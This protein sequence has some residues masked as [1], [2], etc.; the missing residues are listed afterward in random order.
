MKVLARLLNRRATS[1]LK[2]AVPAIVIALSLVAIA[3]GDDGGDQQRQTSPTA[4]SNP[5]TAPNLSAVVVTTMHVVGPNRF[6][7]GIIDQDAGQPVL[8]GQIHFRFFEVEGSQAELR[9]ESD[10]E[11]I[12]FDTFFVN[13]DTG[14]QIITG[15]TGVYVATVEF[16]MAGNWGVEATGTLTGKD[17]EPLRAGFVVLERGQA[18][19][20]GDPAPRSRQ[21]TID[22]V[23]DI[24]E[25]DTMSPHDPMHDI[26][27]ADAIDLG[28]PILVN[29]GTPAFCETR[30][31]GPVMR[32]VML[33]L[34]EKYGEQ[35]TFIHIEPYLLKEAR[36]GTG[37]CPVPVFNREFAAQGLGEGTASCP[38]VSEDQL[39]PP[40][41]SWNLTT[42]PILFLIDADG[43]IAGIFE[44]V[45]G[46]QEVEK[47]L[48]EALLD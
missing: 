45:V 4:A 42:E 16:D 29:L 20:I 22:D 26:T 25:I 8:D 38:K 13:D 6:A 18:L 31:C 46:P 40:N 1:G 43:N 36:E 14:E 7:L 2:L 34:Y 37:L 3:C 33:P 41:E 24:A 19:A 9:F 10:A 23:S 39:P 44:S 32:T 12:S 28:K 35:A 17:I 5:G 15:E 48:Q 21:A 47:A 30:I 11:S 27:V